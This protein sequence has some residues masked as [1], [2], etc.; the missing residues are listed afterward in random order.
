MHTWLLKQK[1]PEDGTEHVKQYLRSQVHQLE[2][3]GVNNYID[4]LNEI[5][6]FL[7]LLPTIKDL[8]AVP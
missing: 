6:K 3:I 8:E 5:N 2:C 4:H 7:P 1:V